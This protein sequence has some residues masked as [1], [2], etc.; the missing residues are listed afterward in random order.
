MYAFDFIFDVCLIWYSRFIEYNAYVLMQYTTVYVF[1]IYWYVY[2][3]YMYHMFDIWL[4][5]ICCTS[6]QLYFRHMR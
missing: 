1:D 6:T 4:K 5:D 3:I 2:I